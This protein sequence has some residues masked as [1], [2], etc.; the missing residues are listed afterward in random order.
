MKAS[1]KTSKTLS[2]RPLKDLAS[3]KM[4]SLRISHIVYGRQKNGSRVVYLVD[5]KGGGEERKIAEQVVLHRWRRRKFDGFSFSGAR[6]SPN[7]WRVLPLALGDQVGNWQKLS[8]EQIRER[9][10]V[11]Q[12]ILKDEFTKLPSANVLHALL[13]ICGPQRVR[14][15]IERHTASDQTEPHGVPD[16]F[17]YAVHLRS[18]AYSIARFVEVKKPEE[19]V[20]PNQHKEIAFLQSLGL[21]ARVL[22][23][24]ERTD[25]V[26]PSKNLH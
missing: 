24:V 20:K 1:V 6:L 12:Q 2:S 13:N 11:N 17:L 8:I 26:S 16:L 25:A 10:A 5:E 21:H 18:G 9:V 19:P 23:L 7:L 15:L 14:Q 4:P 22:R 3:E